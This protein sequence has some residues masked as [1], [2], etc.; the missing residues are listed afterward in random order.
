MAAVG[1]MDQATG[2]PIKELTRLM[3]NTGLKTEYHLGMGDPTSEL[4]R[5][6]N[7]LRHRVHASLF[8]IPVRKE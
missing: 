7:D 1:N 2:Q 6:I 8:I 3:Q 5:M 4:V